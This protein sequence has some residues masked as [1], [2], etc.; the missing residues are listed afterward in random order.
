MIFRISLRN[1]YETIYIL[2]PA[3]FVLQISRWVYW[4]FDL[5]LHLLYEIFN[6]SIAPNIVYAT[7][8]H[9][10]TIIGKAI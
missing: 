7:E 8:K 2:R 9:G 1:H 5:V 6:T 4:P 10:L 3:Y